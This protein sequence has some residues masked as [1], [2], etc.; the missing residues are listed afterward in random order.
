MLRPPSNSIIGTLFL[1]TILVVQTLGFSYGTTL[2]AQTSIG[3]QHAVVYQDPSSDDSPTYHRDMA[4]SGY[5][6]STPQLTAVNLNWMSTALDGNVYAEPLIVGTEVIV[7]TEN[8]SLYEFNATTGRPLWRINL[9]TPVNGAVLPCGNINPSGITGT[10]VIDVPRRTIFVVAFLQSP[11]LHHELFAIDLDTGNAKFQL[12]IDPQ[13]TNPTVQQQ[14]AAL[15]LSNGYVYVAYGGLAGDCGQYHGWLAA[16]NATGVGPVISYQVPTGDAG[17]IWGGG[18]GPVIDGSGDV[19]VATGNSFSTSVFDFGNAV[20][21]LSPASNGPISLVDWFAPSN[22]IQLN[23][24]DLD[25][26]STE[27]VILSSNYIFQIGKA[28]VGYLLNANN[29]GHIGGQLYSSQVCTSGGAYGGLAYSSPYLIVPCTNG[30]VALNVNLGSNPPFTVTWRGPNFLAGPPIIAGNAVWTVDAAHGTIYALNL[31]NG[32]TIFQSTIGSTPTHFNSVSAGDRQ[33][34]VTAN[35]HLFAYLPQAP[36]TIIFHTTPST[37]LGASSPGSISACSG[38]FTDGQSTVCTASFSTTANPPLPSTG[39]QFDNWTW[40]GGV[41]CRTSGD[42]AS[43]STSAVGGSLTAV[44][45]AQVTF[46]TN[47]SS[48]GAL[49][50]WGSCDASGEGDGQ[51]VYSTSYGST[52]ACYVPSG[53]TLSNWSCS[54][55]LTC[56]GS[57]DPTLVTFNGPGNITLN[58]KTGSLSNPL[59][60]SLT[61]FSTPNS[62]HAGT[63]FTVSGKLTLTNGTALGNETIVLVFGWSTNMIPV[64]TQPNG[65]YNYTTTAP[66][67]AGSYNVDAFFLGDFSGSAQYLPSKATAM[68]TVA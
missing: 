46:Q 47:P 13:G 58:L 55:G 12:D 37:F 68:I 60:T 49:I 7:A 52:A 15:A 45:A 30:V 9:G 29:L 23:E 67:L 48:S 21:K 26:G 31:T 43:C 63:T 5:D 22:W 18:D 3:Q 53:Y 35:R 66:A 32:E 57:N 44:Y 64:T 39:W 65:S 61:A 51:S 11:Q 27:P 62:T 8:N 56:S 59:S 41:A 50:S 17:A 16:I 42:M 24:G 20:M 28:G 19:L 38:T 40:S 14:R 4:R 36:R 54:N 34:F 33:I 25:L 1:V 10:P 2:T 6:P